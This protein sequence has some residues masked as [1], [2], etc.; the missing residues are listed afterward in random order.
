MIVT[1]LAIYP[2]YLSDKFIVSSQYRLEKDG[3]KWNPTPCRPLWPRMTEKPTRG[4]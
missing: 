1:S 4:Y 3:S 2:Q